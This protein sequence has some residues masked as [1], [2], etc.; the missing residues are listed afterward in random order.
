VMPGKTIPP[1]PPEVT[2]RDSSPPPPP[3]LASSRVQTLKTSQGSALNQWDYIR[4]NSSHPPSDAVSVASQSSFSSPRTVHLSKAPALR[5]SPALA[6]ARD[7]WNFVL[8]RGG[9]AA[10][11]S[12]RSDAA[13]SV[14][15]MSLGDGDTMSIVS[16]AS[17]TSKKDAQANVRA[18]SGAV[19]LS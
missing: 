7:D 8:G 13:G 4:S 14:S 9:D 1:P 17:M 12:P 16:I 3:P 18:T 6:S 5:Q 15:L 2:R 19:Q 10:P 11:L